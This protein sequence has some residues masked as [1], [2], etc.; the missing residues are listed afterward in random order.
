MLRPLSAD[1]LLALDE[2]L[3]FAMR[4]SQA[5]QRPLSVQQ[6]QSLYDSFLEEEIDAPD[7]LIALG[8]AFGETIVEESNFE[9]VR[10]E[11]EYGEET[12]LSPPGKNIHCAPISMIQKRL[13]RKEAV[14]IEQL[15]DETIKVIRAKLDN[16]EIQDRKAN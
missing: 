7:A 14:S 13:R 8:L 3:A 6:V 1:E 11:D 5:S 12:C 16:N 9:W 4:I 10:A 2:G 15:R